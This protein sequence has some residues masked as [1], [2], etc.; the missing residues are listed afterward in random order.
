MHGEK[1]KTDSTYSTL[2]NMYTRALVDND[3][4]MKAWN[5]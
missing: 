1:E 4:E 3:I 5:D 2:P